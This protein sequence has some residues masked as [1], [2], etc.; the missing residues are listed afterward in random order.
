[1]SRTWR[2]AASNIGWGSE[3]DDEVYGLLAQKGYEG[4]EVAPTLLFPE[5][6]YDRLANANTLAEELMTRYGLSVCSIQSIWYGRN[7]SI[8]DE[9]GAEAL[10]RYTEEACGFAEAIGARNLVFGC[11]KNRNV[12]DGHRIEESWEFIAACASTAASHGATFA[13]EANPTIYGTNMMNSTPDAIDVL[14]EVGAPAGLSVNLDFGTVIANGEGMDD[15]RRAMPFVSHVHVSE[16]RLVPIE[17]RKEHEALRNVLE[18]TQYDG[19]VSI[20][21]GRTDIGTL[22]NVMS[23]VMS[24]FG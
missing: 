19:W 23:Y 15:I 8:Y 1:M 7:E 9:D 13:L 11:P 4:L 24:V 17:R 10:L 21:M 12:P 18:E 16:P 22:A 6:P 3:D 5:R 20:E 14:R 2:L